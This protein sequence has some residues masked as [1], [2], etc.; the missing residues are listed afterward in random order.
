L[1]LEQTY[2]YGLEYEEALSLQMVRKGWVVGRLGRGWDGVL[3]CRSHVLSIFPVII[4]QALIIAMDLMG[5]GR[6]FI[7][8]GEINHLW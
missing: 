2:L 4:T 1:D 7:F 6:L 3:Q 5:T 8:S